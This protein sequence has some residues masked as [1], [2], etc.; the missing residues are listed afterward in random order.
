MVYWHT[1]IVCD[2]H[3]WNTH[4][5]SHHLLRSYEL[6][7]TVYVHAEWAHKR[8]GFSL[9]ILNEKLCLIHGPGQKLLYIVY[10]WLLITNGFEIEICPLAVMNNREHLSKQYSAEQEEQGEGQ[11]T[12]CVYKRVSR[13]E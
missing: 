13:L 2:F 5:D 3:E 4:E 11:C 10:L 12:I 8:L 6:H 7:Q 1:I 9:A